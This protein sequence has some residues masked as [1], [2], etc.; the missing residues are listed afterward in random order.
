MNIG[1]IYIYCGNVSAEAVFNVYDNFDNF[2][3]QEKP[4]MSKTYHDMTAEET[5]LKVCSFYVHE[6]GKTVDVKLFEKFEVK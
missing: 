4:V 1:E 2:V 5:I 3:R 6:D